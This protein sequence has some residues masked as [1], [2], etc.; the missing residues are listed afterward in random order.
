M[1]STVMPGEHMRF[2]E[3][4][5]A[6][7][8]IVTGL[9][10]LKGIAT[11]LGVVFVGGFLPLPAASDRWLG[12]MPRLLTRYATGNPIESYKEFI[13]D[14]V[15]PHS[16]LFANLT[17]FGESAVG[18]GLTFGFLTGI[19]SA[20]GLCLVAAYG[21]AT[22]WQS[23]NQQGFHLLLF[24]CLVVFMIVRAGRHWGLDGWIRRR[25]PRSWLAKVPLG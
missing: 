22:F 15:I 23:P 2:A 6:T 3:R 8:R 24:A 25:H 4:G 20:V 18:L 10:F 16:H 19:A 11:K 17:A 21:L 13:L 5:I 1:R 9:W 7:L 12:T 14:T